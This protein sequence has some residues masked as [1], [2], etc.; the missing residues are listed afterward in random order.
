MQFYVGLHQPSDAKYF[1]RACL[2]TKRLRPRRKYIGPCKTIVDSGGFT[3]IT[4]YG[5]YRHDVNDY[6]REVHR[7]ADGVVD[8]ACIVSQD[9]MCEPFVIKRT[10]LSVKTHQELSVIRYMEI[11]NRVCGSIHVMPVIQ[12]YRPTEYADH[13]RQYG[14][15]L[16]PGMWVGIGSVCKRN[17]NPESVLAVLNAVITERDDLN[18]HGFGLKT[19][20][21]AIPEIYDILFSADSL[22]WSLAA[23]K[24][25]RNPNDWREAKTFERKIS[26]GEG[27]E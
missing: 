14:N 9:Y 19:T 17:S 22:A 23:R 12:G 8:I 4:Q 6:A 18:Y 13:I 7:L 16:K 26:R 25:G 10:G 3:E 24:Q 21:L 2:S 5:R 27:Y 15:L 1:E 11:R 20:A